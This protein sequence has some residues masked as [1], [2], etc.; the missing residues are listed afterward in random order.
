MKTSPQF[1]LLLIQLRTFILF[2][3]FMPGTVLAQP[4]AWFGVALPEGIGDPHAPA[5]DMAG[6]RPVPAIVPRG[7]EGFSELEGQRLLP[8]V[9][10]TIAFSRQSRAEG[11]RMWGRINGFSSLQRT[12]EWVADEFTDAGLLQV[13]VQEY[14]G[15]GSFWW[16]HEWEVKLLAQP[17]FGDGSRDIVLETSM[18]TGDSFIN[19]E[20]TAMLVDSG[21]ISDPLPAAEVIRGRIALQQ[22]TPLTGAYSDRTPTRERAQQLMAAGAVAVINIVEQLGNMHT[23]DFSRCNG[24]CFNIGTSDGEF[25]Q[26]VL[27]RAAESGMQDDVMMSLT[28]DAE[29]LSGLTGHNAI[30]IVPGRNGLAGENVIV[31]AHADGWFDG[32][33]DNADGIAV[34]IGMAR[35]FAENPAD[36]TLIFVASGGH[37]SSGLNGPANF[38]RMNPELTADTVLVLNLEH[39]AQFEIDSS[40]WSVGPAEQAMNFSITNAAP[41]LTD[42]T[43]RAMQRYGFNINPEFRTSAPGDLG[44]YR[45]LGLP[46]IQAIHSGPMY[47]ANGDVFATI[48]EPGLERA[49][50]FFSYFVAEVA[51][52][53]RALIDPE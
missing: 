3:V 35:H 44:G 39:V 2:A 37:H 53:E 29:N 28:L 26:A 49:A 51:A 14:P 34:L 40:D 13:E 8:L 6:V 15:E 30:G 11:H 20:L 16:P 38:V 22:L 9:N 21:H 4:G 27:A 32:A 46:M 41:Y 7:E 43:Q 18:P 25:L 36:R 50:R 52:A 48:S 12:V 31:N 47:H 45:Q 5:V 42:L 10:D 1:C 33:G 19:G 17:A 24:P 23:R